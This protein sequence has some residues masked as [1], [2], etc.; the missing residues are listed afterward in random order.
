VQPLVV[1]L[2]HPDRADDAVGRLVAESV[3]DARGDVSV[4]CPLDPLVLLNL[5]PGRDVVV[6]VDAAVGGDAAGTVR[7]HDLTSAPLAQAEAGAAASSHGISVGQVVEL[8]RAVGAMP[9]MLRLVTVQVTDVAAG[10]ELTPSV[11]RAVARASQQVSRLLDE[12]S[13]AD[14]G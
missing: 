3:A 1:G 12:I 14:P 9:T 7:V 6:L 13:S 4:A 11:R 5:M 10:R 2:G 8:A